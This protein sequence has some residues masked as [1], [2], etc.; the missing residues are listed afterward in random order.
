MTCQC[1][2]GKHMLV[3]ISKSVTFPVG[4]AG[5]VPSSYAVDFTSHAGGAV[6]P[7]IHAVQNTACAAPALPTGWTVRE[8][9]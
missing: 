9:S 8:V 3:D 1:T 7:I 6:L 4:N 5:A 2:C